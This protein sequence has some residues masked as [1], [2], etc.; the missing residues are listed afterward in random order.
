[1]VFAVIP[2][3]LRVQ[4]AVWFMNGLCGLFPAIEALAFEYVPPGPGAPRMVC[5]GT[6][7]A[8]PRP[9]SRNFPLPKNKSQPEGPVPA[10]LA[11]P[12]EATLTR[13]SGPSVP[14]VPLVKALLLSVKNRSLMFCP[15]SF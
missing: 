13:A 6:K 1:M 14:I 10:L 9:L 5:D 2:V 3:I 7:V 8:P 12:L 11:V 4:V 15:T